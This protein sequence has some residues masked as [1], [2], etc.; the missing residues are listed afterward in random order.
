MAELLF[1]L[2]EDRLLFLGS[3]YAVWQPRWIIDKFMAFELPE[4]LQKETRRNLTLEAKRKI[5]GS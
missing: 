3:N 5:L 4:A 1:W 2:G